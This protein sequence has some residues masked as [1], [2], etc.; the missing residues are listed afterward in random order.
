MHINN[1]LKLI[2]LVSTSTLFSIAYQIKVQAERIVSPE[3]LQIVK[4]A[5]EHVDCI[6]DAN[7]RDKMV[8]IPTLN[9]HSRPGCILFEAMVDIDSDSS[10]RTWNWSEGVNTKKYVSGKLKNNQKVYVVEANGKIGNQ[11][12]VLV[13]IPPVGRTEAERFATVELRYLRYLK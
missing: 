5:E 9:G 13:G 12:A 2:I 10:L 8:S 1:S 3:L 11:P 6:T 7:K 4:L